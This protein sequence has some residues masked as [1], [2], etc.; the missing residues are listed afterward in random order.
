VFLNTHSLNTFNNITPVQAL[1]TSSSQQ[2]FIDIPVS[3]RFGVAEI[4]PPSISKPDEKIFYRINTCTPSQ[5]I[6][7]L[8]FPPS[9]LKIDIDGFEY[10]FL[11]GISPE[12]FKSINSIL[13]EVNSKEI[14]NLLETHGFFL[15]A[16]CG[17]NCIYVRGPRS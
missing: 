2:N 14:N 1:I 7:S 5:L 12:Q 4:A 10:D 13:I 11:T 9:V 16:S 8:E 17:P 15:S 3:G 6:N